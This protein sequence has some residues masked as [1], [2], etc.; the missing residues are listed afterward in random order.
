MLAAC[1]RGAIGTLPLIP[2]AIPTT[3][4]PRNKQVSAEPSPTLWRSIWRQ[5]NY[6]LAIAQS[7]QEREDHVKGRKT[8]DDAI[9]PVRPAS[10]ANLRANGEAKRSPRPPLEEN[11]P[12]NYATRPCHR[13]ACTSALP[14]R[15]PTLPTAS[16][17]THRP[18]AGPCL[19]HSLGARFHAST[20]SPGAVTASMSLSSRASFWH[21]LFPASL[22]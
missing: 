1:L 15:R 8:T 20:D 12:Y 17:R 6:P 10:S 7:R 11:T 16:A 5:N 14:L 2:A 3:F 22:F 18:L 9:G 21:D 13:G 4:P 19:R